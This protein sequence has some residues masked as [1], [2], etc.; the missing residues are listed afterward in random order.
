MRLINA[1]FRQEKVELLHWKFRYQNLLLSPRGL[2]AQQSWT[3]RLPVRTLAR[4]E[5]TSAPDS[6]EKSLPSLAKEPTHMQTLEQM[7]RGEN[8]KM[9]CIYGNTDG[10]LRKETEN[11]KCAHMACR[12]E[13]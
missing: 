9:R 11:R 10:L 7:Q 8:K 5:Y 6:G 4:L 2:H 1:A 12:K 3:L 13:T